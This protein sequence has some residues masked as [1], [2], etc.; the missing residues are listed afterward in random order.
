MDQNISEYSRIVGEIIAAG[1]MVLA[2][3]TE[4]KVRHIFTTAKEIINSVSTKYVGH[5]PDNM[6]EIIKLIALTKR[7]LIITCDIPSY[8]HFSNPRGFALYKNAILN[9]CAS[10]S[11]PKII[12]VTYDHER[13]LI[14]S[15]NQFISRYEEVRNG[16][17]YK[18]Y[19]EYHKDN[20]SV[21]QPKELT[22]EG[23][24]N[25]LEDKHKEFII[26]MVNA[27][28][29]VYESSKEIKSFAWISDDSAILS[30]HNYGNELREVSF[31]TSD[32]PLV[33]ILSEFA[34]TTITESTQV[35]L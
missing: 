21:K 11:R 15:K 34:K 26:T 32:Q 10:D 29:E 28:V 8:G 24:C 19:F 1:A 35:I 31:K 17:S 27:G 4:V 2:I 6:E 7:Q 33:D 25:W 9:L 13:R 20:K 3:I 23:F 16:A 22:L 12:I 5:F 30:F 18:K 14:N